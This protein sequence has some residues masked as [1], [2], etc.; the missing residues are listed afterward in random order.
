MQVKPKRLLKNIPLRLPIPFSNRN[1]FII[2]I[3]VDLRSELLG[4]FRWLDLISPP[5]SI[6]L[7][8]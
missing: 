1:E 7:N 3:S 4:H 8:R 6:I 2:E 5:S